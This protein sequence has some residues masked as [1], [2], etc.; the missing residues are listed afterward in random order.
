M[1]SLP[2]DPRAPSPTREER[3]DRPRRGDAAR[4]RSRRAQSSRGVEVAF[5]AVTELLGSIEDD[6]R[7]AVRDDHL[8]ILQPCGA[9]CQLTPPV[10]YE[11]VHTTEYTYSEPV[12]VSHHLARLSPRVS[13]ASGVP[14]PRAADRAGAGRDATH[15]DYF[16]NAV[17]FFIVERRAQARSPSAP[18]A[19]SR[20]KAAACRAVASTP[21]WEDA[22]R[23][24]ALPLEAL[25]C[26][27]DSAPI[28]GERRR[29]A[30]Y[31]HPSFPPGR[32]LLEA[33]LD[34]TRRIHDD[35]TFDPKATTVDDAAARTCFARGA[36]CVRTSRGWRSR[37]CGRSGCRRG[38]SAAISR[39]CRRRAAASA[40][41]RRVACL[42]GR[43]LSGHRLDRRRPDQQRVA[44]ATHV[45]LAWGRDYADVSPIHGVILGGGQHTLRVSVDVL[46]A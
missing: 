14:A 10:Q 9:P 29:S 27:F 20:S 1:R 21:P 25:E 26:L 7:G 24:D 18:E 36:A 2:R 43:L 38:T 30:G 17:T 41:R 34:L 33:V 37:A 19:R 12:A 13:A 16:G 6:L 4:R 40:R 5:D 8:F 23:L 42:A 32:P 31:A 22:S 45:T 11:V 15:Q 28:A 3:I 44:L 46:R 35:F 39:R